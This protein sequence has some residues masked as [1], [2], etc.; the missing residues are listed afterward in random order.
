M[1]QQ[2]REQVAFIGVVPDAELD[3]LCSKLGE[4]EPGKQAEQLARGLVRAK[5]LT[6]FQ[7]QQC[8]AGKAR[9]LVLGDYLIQDK[10]GQGG[11]QNKKEIY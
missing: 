4:V 2:F 3:A 8:Y 11:N 5:K 9:G 6:A 10:I 7:A 1:L